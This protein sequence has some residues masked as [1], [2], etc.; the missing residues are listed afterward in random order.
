MSLIGQVEQI[1]SSQLHEMVKRWKSVGR[2]LVER[3]DYGAPGRWRN[4][5]HF[6]EPGAVPQGPLWVYMT[7]EGAWGYLDFD[8]G[9][10]WPKPTTVAHL[11][12]LTELRLALTGLETDPEVWTSERLLRRRLRTESGQLGAHV[13]DAWFQDIGDP[14]KVWAIEVELS[15]KFGAGRLMAAMARALDAADRHEL[16]GVLYFVRGEALR[17]AVESTGTRLA[18]KRG[19]ERLS[20]LEIHDLDTTLSKKGVR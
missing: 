10:W 7:R 2:V 14:D 17:R 20:N 8:P 15:R 11:T 12:A 9:A 19:V 3:V 16:A 6:D 13:H 5:K 18:H 1:G 4:S